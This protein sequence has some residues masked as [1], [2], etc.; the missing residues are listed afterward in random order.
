MYAP[1]R[2]GE[3]EVL[4]FGFT[5]TNMGK[6]TETKTVYCCLGEGEKKKTYSKEHPSITSPNFFRE[7]IKRCKDSWTILETYAIK[8]SHWVLIHK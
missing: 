6:A 4:E 2:Q 8:T 5:S 1:F 7:A 3:K